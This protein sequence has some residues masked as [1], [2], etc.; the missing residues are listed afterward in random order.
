MKNKNLFWSILLL[1]FF[2]YHNIQSQCEVLETV[3]ICDMTVI[4]YDTDGSM[5]GIINLYDAYN[6]ITG[7]TPIPNTTGA[8]F[9]PN[10]NFALD[11]ASGNL[12]LWDLNNSSVQNATYQFQLFDPTSTC[13]NNL[14][15]T[16]NVV[17]GPFSGF[18]VPT[19]GDNHVNVEICDTPDLFGCSTETH[20]D[21]FQTF[22]STPSPHT[23]GTWSYEGT[24]S[25][26]I[27]IEDNRF[28]KVN[29]PYQAG[30]PLVDEE[31]FELVYKVPGISPCVVERETTVKVSVIRGVFSGI[32]N[33]INICESAIVNGDFDNDINLLDD[34]Y[35][36]NEDIEGIWLIAND[37]TDQ[38]SDPLDSFVNISE[39]YDAILTNN[40][41]FGVNEFMYTYFVNS[42]PSVCF[43][44]ESTIVFRIFE[45]IKPFE[46][47]S[48]AEFCVGHN[49]PSS[50]NLYDFITFSNENNTTYDY[51][52]EECTNWTFVS[53]PSDLGLVTNPSPIC[54]IEEG[55]MYTA[56]GTIDF[57][58]ITNADIGTYVFEYTVSNEYFY[59]INGSE[60]GGTTHLPLP[61]IIYDTPNGCHYN[62]NYN[63]PCDEYT[64]QVT[65][66][67]HPYNY[68]GED[69][70]DLEF[71]ES[72]MSNPINLFTLLE[73]N[74]TDT[75]YQGVDADWIDLDTGN[76][77]NNPY[78]IPEINGEQTFH[79]QYSITANDC[80]ETANL[81]FTLFEQY[82]AGGNA[83]KNICIEDSSFE[84]FDELI[85][86]P[87][88]NGSWSG[89]NGFSSLNNLVNFDP[90]T[91]ETGDYI[92]SVPNNALCETQSATITVN[93]I[94]PSVAG[95]NVEEN[96]CKIDNEIDLNNLLDVN[97]DLGG[98]FIDLDNTNALNGSMVNL[99]QLL[100]SSYSFQ[101]D[102][103]LNALCSVS[104]SIITII[105]NE[106]D[107][108]IVSDQVFCI[109]YGATISDIEINSSQNDYNWYD[110][111][112]DELTLLSDLI[113]SN[114]EDYYVAAVNEND[115]ESERVQVNVT[116]IPFGQDGCIS[117]IN[118]G[119]SAN[120]DSE[121]DDL[122]LCGLPNIF[123]N[124]E[125]K[126]FNR[127]GN[128]IYTGNKN[129]ALFNGTSNV[130]L[131]LGD[132]VPAGVYF[133]IFYPNNGSSK[134]FQGDFYLSR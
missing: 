97:A 100:N 28:L 30:I 31:V 91:F 122:G 17:L 41:R 75:I 55:S 73:T 82:Q 109:G 52:N 134:P 74:G 70:L 121:N 18:A 113:L 59:E 83:V 39:I 6:A 44:S 65:L 56:Q 42:R 9:D 32:A 105:V 132:Q 12:R 123:P 88:D 68:P 92:Y 129:S 89:P 118:D 61:E 26:F 84:L 19:T 15:V 71:C 130:A 102:V 77:I 51:P 38:L 4:D 16:L 93:I 95:D 125:I 120:N 87:D 27:E 110:N 43:N 58:N 117:C 23:N 34:D 69:T 133:Y 119:V 45:S 10:Y 72:D 99:T 98:I 86:N 13:A 11:E 80:F 85:G 127:Y 112:D 49:N 124:F 14:L 67:I 103:Q 7:V 104:S 79:F 21:L 36:V 40:P 78:T 33:H 131:T 5:D 48:P 128:V 115:C 57:S 90:A 25:N 126:I 111:I 24:S 50:L 96:V 114:D 116:L 53:G 35:L 8:W 101:Y 54:Y 64:A 37:T 107:S 106:V 108:P 62:I 60:H 1:L 20:F 22:L 76:V 81:T 63:H 29:I 47:E 3:I 94:S 2:Q 66:I 46:Q